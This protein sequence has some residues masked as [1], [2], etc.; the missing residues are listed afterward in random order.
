MQQQVDEPHYRELY[1]GTWMTKLV[2]E[3]T[4]KSGIIT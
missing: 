2:A 1:I 3:K 4:E